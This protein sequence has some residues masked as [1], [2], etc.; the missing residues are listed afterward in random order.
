MRRVYFKAENGFTF[1][2]VLVAALILA[3]VS[4]SVFTYFD[5]SLNLEESSRRQLEALRIAESTLEGQKAIKI[6]QLATLEPEYVEGQYGNYLLEVVVT[7]PGP[8]ET[9]LVEVNVRYTRD[10]REHEV[11]LY[12]ERGIR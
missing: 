6:E 12:L 8:G 1:L 3:M 9:K 5:L 11:L 10:S 2:E 7:E 4:V